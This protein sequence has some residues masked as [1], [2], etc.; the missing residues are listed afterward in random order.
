MPE[1]YLSKF[2]QIHCIDFNERRLVK[3][4]IISASIEK[5]DCDCSRSL[6]NMFIFPHK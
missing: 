5:T 6:E 4:S 1:D 2:Q 3:V